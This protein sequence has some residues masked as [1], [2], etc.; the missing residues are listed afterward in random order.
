MYDS[1]TLDVLYRVGHDHAGG[2]VNVVTASGNWIIY[3]YWNDKTKRTELSAITLYSGLVPSGGIT[4][5]K[6]EH[7][8]SATVRS[9]YE[10]YGAISLQRTYWYGKAITGMGVTKTRHGITPASIVLELMNG[11]V[12]TLDLRMLD[13]RRPGGDP[14][15]TE[16]V[17]GGRGE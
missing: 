17:R 15:M 3:S 10:G 6:N 14:K 2:H 8:Q 16:K 4:M 12:A 13:P 5:F 9:R 1:V 7:P 11:Q